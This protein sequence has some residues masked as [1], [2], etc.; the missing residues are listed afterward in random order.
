[1]NRNSVHS[2]KERFEARQNDGRCSTMKTKQ[3]RDKAVCPL[4][5]NSTTPIIKQMPKKMQPNSSL[6]KKRID[7]ESFSVLTNHNSVLNEFEK[8]TNEYFKNNTFDNNNSQSKMSVLPATP[9]STKS[10]I[11]SRAI[12]T[13]DFTPSPYDESSLTLKVF[14]F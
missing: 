11:I 4:L 14:Y 10:N 13:T 3:N 12:A 6:N 7:S 1:M 2:L 5:L 9:K 8:L